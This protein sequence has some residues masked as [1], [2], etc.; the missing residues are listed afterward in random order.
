MWR[1]ALKAVVAQ[2]RH[3]AGE[4]ARLTQ[5]L[6]QRLHAQRTAHADLDALR[7]TLLRD[8]R[9]TEPALDPK[10]RAHANV[11]ALL[12][13]ARARAEI[14]AQTFTATLTGEHP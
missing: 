10:Q 6:S 7:D 4:R 1:D 9:L 11:Q 3:T 2:R 8:A 14:D 5:V 13:V 12:G